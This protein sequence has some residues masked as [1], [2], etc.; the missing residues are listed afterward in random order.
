MAKKTKRKKTGSIKG[1]VCHARA[2]FF[3]PDCDKEYIEQA[4]FTIRGETDLK[5]L[6]GSEGVNQVIADWISGL[7]EDH[8]YD[9][10]RVRFGVDR[11]VALR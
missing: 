8:G 3:M 10:E 4:S 6:A 11:W 9:R 1:F 2:V 5:M 7:I